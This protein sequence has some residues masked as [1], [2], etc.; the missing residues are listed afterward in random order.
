VFAGAGTFG[1]AMVP[2]AQA[3]T[4]KHEVVSVMMLLECRAK[5]MS[6][7]SP[8]SYDNRFSF[9]NNTLVNIRGTWLP[10]TGTTQ[11]RGRSTRSLAIPTQDA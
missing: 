8:T 7:S 9:H 10:S 3:S 5:G 2:A 6:L 1:I 11:G 4:T